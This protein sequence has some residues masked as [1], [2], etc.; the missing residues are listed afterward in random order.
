[1]LAGTLSAEWG[2][3]RIP[4]VKPCTSRSRPSPT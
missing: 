1:M 3:Y 2:F 4:R